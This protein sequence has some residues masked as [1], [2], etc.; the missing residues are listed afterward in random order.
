VEEK[1]AKR[2]VGA[3]YVEGKNDEE[4]VQKK[5]SKHFISKEKMPAI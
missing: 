1:D 3:L 5:S 2:N 4:K